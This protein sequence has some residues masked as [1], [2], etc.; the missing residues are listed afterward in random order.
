MDESYYKAQGQCQFGIGCVCT[1]KLSSSEDPILFCQGKVFGEILIEH[2][3]L[4]KAPTVT[5]TKPKPDKE[6]KSPLQPAQ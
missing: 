5:S 3:E 4:N 6:S 1:P 2:L